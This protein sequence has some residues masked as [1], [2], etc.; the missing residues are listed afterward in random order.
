M[1][2]CPQCGRR[3]PRNR[4]FCDRQCWAA[5]RAAHADR[6]LAARARRRAALARDFAAGTLTEAQYRARLAY[7]HQHNLI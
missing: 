5:Y 6:S 4:K 2:R 1:S 3:T 7:Y